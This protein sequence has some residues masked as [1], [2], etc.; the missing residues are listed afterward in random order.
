[1]IWIVLFIAL[2]WVGSL[3][4]LTYMVVSAVITGRL[5]NKF[6]TVLRNERPKMF[7]WLIALHTTIIGGMAYFTYF[8]A[9]AP[10]I[11]LI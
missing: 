10:G 7:W 1:M 5:P 4:G 3:V 11:G 2:V 8:V 9:S 6:E